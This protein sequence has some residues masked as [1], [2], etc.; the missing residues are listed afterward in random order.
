MDDRAADVHVVSGAVQRQPDGAVQHY[1]HRGHPDHDAGV[2][3]YRMA[4]TLSSFVEDESGGA[5]QS[6]SVEERGQHTGAMVAIGL[7]LIRRPGLQIDSHEREQ[8][9]EEVAGVV[10]GLGEQLPPG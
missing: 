5:D 3:L 2:N 10:S 6:Q 7:G 8:Q 4:Q 1:T 9:G